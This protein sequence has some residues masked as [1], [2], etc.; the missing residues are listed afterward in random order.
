[1]K[2][3]LAQGL[4]A[5]LAVTMVASLAACGSSKTAETTAAETKAE[6]AAESQAEGE[7]K[8]EESGAS[9]VSGEI[10]FSW[11]GG[12]SRHEATEKAVEAFM[13]KYPNVSVKTEYGAWSGWE[14]KQALNLSSGNGADLMQI[15]WNWIDNYSQGGTNFVDLYQYS[16]IIDL[17]QFPQETLDQCSVDGKLMGI[18]VSN[19]GCLFFWNAKTFETIG[20]DIPTD[21]ESLMAAGQKFKEYGDD[22]YP[23]AIDNGFSHM[24]FLVYYLES[25]Y[26]KPWVENGEMQY[27]EEEIQ[28]GMEFMKELED[29]HVIPTMKVVAGDM[30]DSLDKNPKWIDGKYAGTFVWDASSIKMADAVEESVNVEGQTLVQGDYLKF[31]D[32]NGGYTKISM[33]YA[34]PSSSQNPEAAATLLNYLLNDPEGVEICAL[35]RGVPLSKAGVAVIEEKNIGDPALIQANQAALAYC[36][37]PLDPKFDSADL[38]ASPDGVYEKV[39]GKLSSDDYTPEEAAKVL[40]EGVNEVLGN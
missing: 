40:T 17:T 21:T 12:D 2:K 32:Y 4:S 29:N 11:W 1:M 5:A 3:R 23:L 34:I 26:G 37:F 24:V 31:G 15:N 16:D 35:E 8:A 7:S 14:E 6:T 18:P 39:F 22:Y 25:V 28:T 9:D 36:K 20:C 27:T 30:A 13:K 19:T 38:K 10:T 33:A